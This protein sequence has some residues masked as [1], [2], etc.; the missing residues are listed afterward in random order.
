M[1]SLFDVQMREAELRN[2]NVRSNREVGSPAFESKLEAM[3]QSRASQGT[4]P[5]SSFTPTPEQFGGLMP[6]QVTAGPQGL[7]SNASFP[8]GGG[9]QFTA[10]PDQ[11]ASLGFPQVGQ[12]LM[13]APQDHSTP[14]GNQFTPDA[15]AFKALGFENVGGSA[16]ELMQQTAE[17]MAKIKKGDLG[18]PNAAA[19]ASKFVQADAAAKGG[20]GMDIQKPEGMSS[21]IWKGFNDEF[22]LTTIGLTLLATNANG[23]NLAANL[24]FALQAG[25]AAKS[26]DKFSEANARV[27][28]ED[29]AM[30]ASKTQ[31]E[32]DYNNARVKEM[33]NPASTTIAGATDLVNL[34]LKQLEL[35]DEQGKPNTTEKTVAKTSA[36]SWLGYD[37]DDRLDAEKTK[38]VDNV[39]NI[40]AGNQAIVRG[41]LK[42][43]NIKGLTSIEQTTL[44][45]MVMVRNNP[46]LLDNLDEGAFEID[47][48]VQAKL[49]GILQTPNGAHFLNNVI[50]EVRN[51]GN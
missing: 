7:I 12:D 8:Q 22:D 17:T 40:F 48:K 28:A 23:Q 36:R 16:E 44:A 3:V 14:Q 10:S 43:S 2:P 15:E 29:R 25:K 33:S 34:Q 1:P 45:K 39:A 24:G 9:N 42:T 27:R 32:I 50:T 6:P 30:K 37:V 18:D 5:M 26:N 35:G 49:E 51:R 13:Q 19:E 20:G 31:S 21:A 11:F 47:A 4:Q 41:A 46:L 38:A